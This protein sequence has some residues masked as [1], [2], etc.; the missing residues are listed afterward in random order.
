MWLVLGVLFLARSLWASEWSTERKSRNKLAFHDIQDVFFRNPQRS[1]VIN[2]HS[3]SRASKAKDIDNRELISTK[4]SPTGWVT[5]CRGLEC[6]STASSS[7]AS[8]FLN[9]ALNVLDRFPSLNSDSKKIFYKPELSLAKTLAT[10]AGV[11]ETHLQNGANNS[12]RLTK[13]SHGKINP[14]YNAKRQDWLGITEGH[15]IYGPH[16]GNRQGPIHVMDPFYSNGNAGNMH[17]THNG[18]R[19]HHSPFR[20]NTIH[21]GNMAPPFITHHRRHP[22]PDFKFND[23]PIPPYPD[24]PGLLPNTG[25]NFPIHHYPDTPF[26]PGVMHHPVEGNFPIHNYPDGQAI[27]G[28]VHHA[29]A[30][31]YA[32][33]PPIVPGVLHHEMDTTLP[34]HHFAD[35]PM[36]PDVMHT[37]AVP[38]FPIHHYSGPPVPGIVHQAANGEL[39]VHHYVEPSGDLPG[40][41]HQEGGVNLPVHHFPGPPHILNGADALHQAIVPQQ[42]ALPVPPPVEPQIIPFPA[43]PPVEVHKV[44]FPVPYPVPLPPQIKEVPIP[45]KVP[46]RTPPEVQ[47]YYYP[48]GVPQP[49]Q[50]HHVPYPVYIRQPPQVAP[51]FVRVLSPPERI[52]VAIPS[53]PKIVVQRVPYPIL[54]PRPVH[55]IHREPQ[56]YSES[57]HCNMNPCV[58]G[59]TCSAFKEYYKCHCQ[60]GFKGVHCEEQS[61]CHPN[62]CRN[63]GICTELEKEYECTCQPGY[64]GINC[65]LPDPCTPTPCKNSAI[66]AQVGNS[67]DCQCKIGWIGRDCGIESKCLPINPCQNGGVCSEALGSYHCNCGRA[68]Q[69]LNCEIQGANSPSQLWQ[70]STHNMNLPTGGCARCHPNAYCNQNRCVCYPGY[71]GNGIVCDAVFQHKMMTSKETYF[72]YKRQRVSSGKRQP[73][74]NITKQNSSWD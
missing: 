66:C 74:P 13:K 8:N 48:V 31:N 35:N 42:I 4:I 73:L 41:L 47:K 22:L 56:L 20:G 1:S 25:V 58:N 24:L 51:Y 68:W 67:Y 19:V 70:P 43:P 50:I 6:V 49:G 21:H 65:E 59:G 53:P 15:N 32:E 72:P 30:S 34:V 44:P 18:Y 12:T 57:G 45:I 17:S 9:K 26:A 3:S 14:D 27:P 11:E 54:I 71:I 55:I 63:L 40:F 16:L 61:R 60:E 23:G 52:P 2:R 69:G 28:I 10:S 5:K 37:A 38:T 62:P 46:V 39:P 7:S 36:V 64:K 33:T 29:T